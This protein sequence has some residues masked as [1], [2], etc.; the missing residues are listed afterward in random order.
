VSETTSIE[1]TGSTWTPIRAQRVGTGGVGWHCERVSPGCQNCYAERM[2]GW[3]GTGLGYKA[4]ARQAVKVFLDEKLLQRPLG[5][6]RPRKVFVCS[7][8]DLFAD[9]VADEQI[10]R[11]LD[12]CVQ[13]HLQRGHTMQIL[14]KRAARM[15][16]LV[17]RYLDEG[18]LCGAGPFCR[19]QHGEGAHPALPAGIWLGVSVEDQQR[20]DERIPVLMQVPAAVRWLSIEPLLGAVTINCPGCER[21]VDAHLAPDQGG[22]PGSFPDW[23]VAGAESG[24]GARP[25]DEAWV[26]SLRDQCVA[27][28]VPFFYKQKLVGGKK[29]GTPE[30]DGRMWTEFPEVR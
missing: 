2:N 29:V 1:W 9:F 26:R 14:T 15:A 3:I 19:E 12:I 8:T 30:L 7:M 21:G 6:T 28:S 11:V 10:F 24:P 13:A 4:T 16:T 27:A 23:V 20:A 5:W 17:R 22:C 18:R 25:M